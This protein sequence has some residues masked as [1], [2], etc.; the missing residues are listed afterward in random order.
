MKNRQTRKE[1]LRKLYNV[2]RVIKYDKKLDVDLVK[3]GSLISGEEIR[4]IKERSEALEV[5]S[6]DDSFLT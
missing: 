3:L 2:D 4:R 1:E 6:N 5:S